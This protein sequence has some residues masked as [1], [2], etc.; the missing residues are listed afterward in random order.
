[1]QEL[2]KG[3]SELKGFATHRRNNDINQPDAPELPGTKPST[4]QYTWRAPW[5]EPY[6]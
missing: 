2:E 3:L 4:K 5:L 1:M 6:M